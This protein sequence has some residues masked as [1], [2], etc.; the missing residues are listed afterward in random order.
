MQPTHSL[1]LLTKNFTGGHSFT[2]CKYP[3]GSQSLGQYR[4][5]FQNA[6]QG[7]A[8]WFIYFLLFL[9]FFG[10][11]S[12]WLSGCCLPLAQGVTLETWD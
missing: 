3:N 11:I 12:G 4:I 7:D 9:K 2:C 8:G 1:S 5:Y 6:T 10:W